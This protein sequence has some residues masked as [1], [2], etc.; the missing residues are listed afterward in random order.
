MDLN[1]D[2]VMLFITNLYCYLIIPNMEN[3]GHLSVRKALEI[4][5]FVF[6]SSQMSPLNIQIMWETL[7]FIFVTTYHH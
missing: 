5:A 2:F 1:I 7:Q 4:I 3:L 6:C